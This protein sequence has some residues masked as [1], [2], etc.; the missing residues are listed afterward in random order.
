MTRSS[1]RDPYT[2]LG[3]SRSASAEEIKRAYRDLAKKHH[4]DRNQNDKKS[5]QKL[6]EINAAND[7]LS[8]PDRRRRYDAGEIDASGQDTFAG[9]NSGGFR[10]A[11]RRGSARRGQGARSFF[12]PSDFMSDD[13]LGDIFGGRTRGNRDSATAPATRD[14]NYTLNVPFAEATLGGK[15]SIRLA[16]GKEVTLTVPPGTADGT[17]LR[18]KGQGQPP[19]FGGAPGDAYIQIK[20]DPHPFFKREGQD[21]HCEIP[22]SLTE[23]VLGATIR[24]PTLSGFVEVRVPPNAN[25]G[26]KLRL[27]GKG[28]PAATHDGSPGDQYIRLSVMLP[29]A[30]DD[31]LTRFLKD[32]KP[33]H[34]F[35]PRRKAGLT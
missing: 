21:I 34:T 9:F 23:A 20:V 35:D 28:V 17:R 24:V 29:D 10:D 1:V 13:I 19:R 14:V 27:K 32:W 6:K 12:D 16:D 25:T 33:G 26:T 11:P 3:V 2:V 18:L 5:E 30:P 8:D 22:V 31:A 15:R 7:F 4:P